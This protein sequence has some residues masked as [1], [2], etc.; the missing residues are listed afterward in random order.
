[1]A[2]ILGRESTRLSALI[3]FLSIARWVKLRLALHRRPSAGPPIALW[4]QN[5]TASAL[6]ARASGARR[7]RRLGLEAGPRSRSRARSPEK[8]VGVVVANPLRGRPASPPLKR[9]CGRIGCCVTDSR[10]SLIWN[11]QGWLKKPIIL[12]QFFGSWRLAE[13]F[14]ELFSPVRLGLAGRD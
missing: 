7:S 5:W 8:V 11:L 10:L 2:D 1:M 3:K 13:I 4:G 9:E 14:P 6:V 12:T